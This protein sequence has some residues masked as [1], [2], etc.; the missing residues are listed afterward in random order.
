MIKTVLLISFDQNLKMSDDGCDLDTLLDVLSDDDQ[1]Q[2]PGPLEEEE[3][4]N[5]APETNNLV[6]ED[7]NESD[8]AEANDNNDDEEEIRKQV[9]FL[10]CSKH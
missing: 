6:G 4:L 7:V 8:E 10:F 5:L 3:S 9:S 2:T 1:E